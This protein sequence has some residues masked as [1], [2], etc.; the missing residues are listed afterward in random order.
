MNKKK[1]VLGSVQ[2][3]RR[4]NQDCTFCS[5]P[6]SEVELPYRQ[7][8]ERMND[9]KNSGATEVM[10]SGGEP[11]LR[12]DLPELIRLAHKIGFQEVSIQTNGSRLHDESLLKT[13]MDAGEIKFDISFHSFKKEIFEKLTGEKSSFENFIK[14][15]NNVRKY[16]IPAYYTTVIN[17]LNYKY[18]KDQIM[19]AE[20]HF[21][22][23]CH[24]SFNFVDP[25]NNASKNSWIVPRLSDVEPYMHDAFDYILKQGMSFRIE[26]VPLCFLSKFREYSSELRR[27]VFNEPSYAVF[28]NKEDLDKKEVTER[29]NQYFKAPQCKLC[30]LTD[31][32]A[33]LNARYVKIHGFDELVPIKDD[34]ASSENSSKSTADH[35]IIQI[36]NRCNHMCVFCS[37]SREDR[38]EVPLDQLKQKIDFFVRRGVS[39]LTFSGGEPTLNKD[40]PVLLVY[41]KEKGIK[42]ITVQTNGILL[43][44]KEYLKKITDSFPVNFLMSFHAS[45]PE[46]YAKITGLKTDYHLALKSLEHINKLNYGDHG[47]GIVISSLNYKHLREHI[48][49]L[50]SNFPNI[51]N[52]NLIFID[53][54]NDAKRNNWTVARMSKV[55]PN[56]Y[57]TLEYIRSNNL[58]A[59]VDRMPLCYLRGF[60]EFSAN[61]REVVQSTANLYFKI[62]EGEYE[63]STSKHSFLDVCNL[64]NLRTVCGGLPQ[65]YIDEIGSYEIY[66]VFDD[67]NK[68]IEKIKA[69]L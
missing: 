68:V 55:E 49:F 56:L 54:V 8:E 66:P 22:N 28:L 18:L 25:T 41:A 1:H 32:C 31:K 35:A 12:D 52:Y 7:V 9:L 4:C 10:F 57:E 43:S 17:S 53:P 6:Q 21:P 19:F 20:K 65:N 50:H 37:V 59:V 13:Y 34:D 40:L 3:T 63:Y 42:N 30:V 27:G 36:D 48:E 26:F 45:E 44:N 51:R 39:Q 23:I 5:A 60:E 46:L 69:K 11:T 61:S 24:F 38:K 47:V 2:V 14:F 33:G 67:V 29:S 64:C 15:L 16:N 62:N 58:N